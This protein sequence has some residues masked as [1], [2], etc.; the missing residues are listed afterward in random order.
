MARFVVA[1]LALLFVL[2]AA[3]AT[4]A[5]P[6]TVTVPQPPAWIYNKTEWRSRLYNSLRLTPAQVGALET[7]LD[8][9]DALKAPLKNATWT[10]ARATAATARAKARNATLARALVKPLIS[11]E[12]AT[13]VAV[14]Q[15]KERAL[16]STEI[17]LRAGATAVASA[18]AA[19]GA[20]ATVA[21]AL[22]AKALNLTADAVDK[23]LQDMLTVDQYRAAARR[24]KLQAAELSVAEGKGAFATLG[25]F[26]ESTA[27]VTTPPA[28]ISA[29]LSEGT[30]AAAAAAAAAA[31]QSPEDAAAAA[32]FL[33]AAAALPTAE[34]D[35]VTSTTP[36]RDFNDGSEAAS[37][38]PLAAT[39]VFA[40]VG[41]RAPSAPHPSS[42]V[43][44]SD[45][46]IASW[47]SERPS[48]ADS[49]DESEHLSRVAAWVAAAEELSLDDD[50]EVSSAT[51][52]A[53]AEAALAGV[54]SSDA[55]PEGG[56][57]SPE[58][59][60]E[61]R[62]ASLELPASLSAAARA[63]FRTK[64]P[65]GTIVRSTP[66]GLGTSGEPTAAVG[67]PTYPATSLDAMAIQAEPAILDYY[68]Y[69]ALRCMGF[70]KA[71][72][73]TAVAATGGRSLRTAVKYCLTSLKIELADGAEPVWVGQAATPYVIPQTGI[74]NSFAA[75]NAQQAG[76]RRS[77]SLFAEAPA[78]PAKGETSAADA[79]ATADDAAPAA[80]VSLSSSPPSSTAT[81]KLLNFGTNTSPP[82]P[83]SPPPPG[84][85]PGPPSPSPPPSPPPAFGSYAS[86]RADTT[87]LSASMNGG[88]STEPP[89]GGLCAGAGFV[90][91]MENEV[92]SVRTQA[93]PATA[94]RSVSLFTFFQGVSGDGF[95]DPHCLYHA[96][97]GRFFAVAYQ[98][99]SSSAATF[100]PLAVS[101]VNDPVRD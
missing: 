30:S 49:A 25:S 38:P 48:S 84:P 77:R 9:R 21:A 14:T 27:P 46:E 96:P 19:A 98:T 92:A 94:V 36:V 52:A 17:K 85:S 81:R 75:Q 60:E 101:A 11:F 54:A 47:L 55:A 1:A 26:A 15:A 28:P 6:L 32:A 40:K 90:L 74:V 82:P 50:A 16:N 62:P 71:L 10:L 24:S 44:A 68:R 12:N 37:S 53:E 72:S 64:Y 76:R 65:N 20:P 80:P 58:V 22:I 69:L 45:A 33:A 95:G 42:L 79:A 35:P 91:S 5:Q 13:V 41:G 63:F 100:I 3:T 18:G 67:A 97:S 59:A 99:L 23:H 39:A 61:A 93:D 56:V 83:P 7:V 87:A 88:G 70:P 73:A 66:G 34:F 57:T 43:D 86:F 51:Y 29:P 8:A 4:S 89:D 31:T 78:A 2:F